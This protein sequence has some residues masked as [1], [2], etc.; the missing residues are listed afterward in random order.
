MTRTGGEHHHLSP[1]TPLPHLRRPWCLWPP[2][3]ALEQC[4]VTDLA[5]AARICMCRRVSPFMWAN[6]QMFGE[7]LY[8][9][10]NLQSNENEKKRPLP[11]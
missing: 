2:L 3:W 7:G 5:R 11:C 10:I 4:N 1:L 9:V 6:K 8:L